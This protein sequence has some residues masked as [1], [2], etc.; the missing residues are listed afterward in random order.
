VGLVRY[1]GWPAV[2]LWLAWRRD[3]RALISCWGIAAWLLARYAFGVR[4][5]A[6]SPVDFDDWEGLASRTTLS[7]WLHDAWKWARMEWLSGG[8]TVLGFAA[9]G[10]WWRWRDRWVAYML[11]NLGAQ[12]AA[13]AGWLA[14]LEVATY[15]M[16]VVPTAVATLPAALGAGIAW[17]R[18]PRLRPALAVAMVAFLGVA[19]WEAEREARVEARLNS[20]ERHAAKQMRLQCEDCRWAVTPRTGIGTRDRHDGCEVLQGTTGWRHGKE[21][22]CMTWPDAATHATTGTVTWT[23]MG[24]AVRVD[25][26]DATADGA[27]TPAGRLAP[28]E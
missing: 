28:R 5:H 26:K 17:E 15:R 6:F 2:V 18:W 8:A 7:S 10:A 27:A 9:F 11:L 20:F 4:G 3:P 1:E 14:G 23:G 21:F 19:F 16:L 25:P 22:V 13:L 24:Y 12:L